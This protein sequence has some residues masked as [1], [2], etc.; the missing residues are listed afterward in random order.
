[1]WVNMNMLN[2]CTLLNLKHAYYHWYA[3]LIVKVQHT[4]TWFFFTKL[5]YYS[6]ISVKDITQNNLI[7]LICKNF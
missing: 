4:K 5:F 3:V 1:M 7:F 2:N 6:H